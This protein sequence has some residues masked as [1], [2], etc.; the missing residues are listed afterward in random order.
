M[1]FVMERREKRVELGPNDPG[2]AAITAK[3][4]TANLAISPHFCSFER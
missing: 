4:T 1:I 3:H 2:L